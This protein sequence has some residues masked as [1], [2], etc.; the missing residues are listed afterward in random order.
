MKEA[1]TEYKKA[2]NDMP[3]VGSTIGLS[4]TDSI[5]STVI[6]GLTMAAFVGVAGYAMSTTEFLATGST[7]LFGAKKILESGKLFANKDQ[8]SEEFRG[9]STSDLLLSSHAKDLMSCLS[10]IEENFFMDLLTL[11]D[12]A[13]QGID[14]DC[15]ISAKSATYRLNNIKAKILAEKSRGGDAILINNLT[16]VCES[17]RKL[18]KSF[19]D[20]S[21]K[22][23]YTEEKVKGLKSSLKKVLETISKINIKLTASSGVPS[24][25][26]QGPGALQQAKTFLGFGE[27][28]SS[29]KSSLQAAHTKLEVTKEQLKSVEEQA[30]NAM[31]K[32]LDVTQRLQENLMQLSKFEAEGATHAQ[33]MEVLQQGLH[34]FGQL[35]EQWTKLLT[36]FQVFLNRFGQDRMC[37][38][39]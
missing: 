25:H 30:D 6:P 22:Q 1:H 18:V 9:L 2:L 5:C 38:V 11:N 20:T 31:A 15:C 37:R 35:K 21:K 33:V 17:S 32:Q 8:D 3:G 12:K 36:F 7:L 10:Q 14:K 23:N 39:R 27:K 16:K 4:L 24:I 34:A 19:L 26:K 28:K 13:I 29:V